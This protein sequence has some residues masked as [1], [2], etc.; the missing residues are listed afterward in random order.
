MEPIVN[1]LP[2]K[3]SL[4]AN[5]K[6]LVETMQELNF[7]RIEQLQIRA[8][9]PVFSPAP[10]LVQDIKIGNANGGPRPELIREDFQLKT[11]VLELFEHLDRI[12]TGTVEIV[13]VRCGLPFRV[14]VERSCGE[15]E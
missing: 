2:T 9:E 15:L 3:S 14:V 8:G 12:S 5:R 7:G 6:R 13:E 11:S 1:Y 4:T 10:R